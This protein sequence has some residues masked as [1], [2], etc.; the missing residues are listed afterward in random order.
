MDFALSVVI[1]LPNEYWEVD[2]NYENEVLCENDILECTGSLGR[3][4]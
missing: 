3:E 1:Y 2:F 4:I